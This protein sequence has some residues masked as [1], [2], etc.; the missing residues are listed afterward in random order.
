M[1]NRAL[2]RCCGFL[3]G[4][5]VYRSPD[6]AARTRLL[7]QADA[8]ERCFEDEKRNVLELLGNFYLLF[9]CMYPEG[10][11]QIGFAFAEEMSRNWEMP[12]EQQ[13]DVL[14]QASGASSEASGIAP[15][16]Q[17][18]YFM[19]AV[20]YLRHNFSYPVR[21]EQLARQIGVSRSYLY[22]AFWNCSGKSIRQYLLDLRL[23]E[24]CRLLADTRRA[25]TDI[26]YSCGFPD[27]PSFC[28][29]FRKVY[30]ET[31]L[32]YRRRMAEEG[33]DSGGNAALSGASNSGGGC[34]FE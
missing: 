4:S 1:A 32:Q 26:A 34:S 3:P 22:K 8:F 7:R 2:L 30:G 16:G 19:Q 24:A 29:M 31:P 5:L 12:A 11:G 23:E 21:I 17:E 20:S 27:S 6:E 18:L 25:V 13:A 10:S 28:R 9:S 33:A 15:S 14:P